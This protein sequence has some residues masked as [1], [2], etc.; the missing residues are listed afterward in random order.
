[1]LLRCNRCRAQV[2]ALL[3]TEN[4]IVAFWEKNYRG[5]CK[6]RDIQSINILSFLTVCLVHVMDCILRKLNN[7]NTL[8]NND[9]WITYIYTLWVKNSQT[10]WY[11]LSRELCW[12]IKLQWGIQTVTCKQ[13]IV[14]NV[15]ACM[16]V[17]NCSCTWVCIF[18][19]KMCVRR[20][21]SRSISG[22]E[23]AQKKVLKRFKTCI[24]YFVFQTCFWMLLQ[25]VQGRWKMQR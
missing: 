22:F 15:Y 2:N 25:W 14:F 19:H 21:P 10:Q 7:L 12:R 17:L 6:T 16:I 3:L 8:W 11:L 13:S 5:R 20:F 24:F 1:M 18:K 4:G 9:N 23:N